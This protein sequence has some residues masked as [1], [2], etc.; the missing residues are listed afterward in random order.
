MTSPVGPG[1][2]ELVGLGLTGAAF[3][4]L[5]VGGGYWIG[6]ITGADVVATFVGLGIGVV[7]AIV[8]TYVRI[9]KYL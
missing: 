4:G 9:R 5:G 3:V 7:T 6:Q 8:A 1:L 2:G